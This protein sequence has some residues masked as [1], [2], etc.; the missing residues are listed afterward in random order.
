MSAASDVLP[1]GPRHRLNDLGL[2]PSGIEAPV[3]SLRTLVDGSGE[4][5]VEFRWDSPNCFLLESCDSLPPTLRL[6]AS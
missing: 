1:T 6:R 4:S 5:C 3:I 2:D